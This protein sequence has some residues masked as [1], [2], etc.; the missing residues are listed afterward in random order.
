MPE[1]KEISAKQ[2]LASVYRGLRS[3]ESKLSPYLKKEATYYPEVEQL[4]TYLRKSP[5]DA[6]EY[7]EKLAEWEDILISYFG[8]L[9]LL[10]AVDKVW[11]MP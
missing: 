10:P 8:H 2:I 3:I 9:N 4:K 5:T 1:T 7:Y 11:E 6:D